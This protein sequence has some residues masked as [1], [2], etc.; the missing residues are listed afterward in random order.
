MNHTSSTVIH[1]KD[2]ECKDESDSHG[3]SERIEHSDKK[4]SPDSSVLL[5]CHVSV[6]VFEREL[7]IS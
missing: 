1:D 2:Q 5:P 4:Y 6:P 7:S 3:D